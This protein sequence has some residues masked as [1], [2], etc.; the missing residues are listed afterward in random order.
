MDAI[1]ELVATAKLTAIPKAKLPMA[2]PSAEPTAT[3]NKKAT[4]RIIR[5]L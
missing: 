3:L 2:A 5:N 4:G 1:A